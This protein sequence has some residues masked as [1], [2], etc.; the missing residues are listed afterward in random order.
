MSLPPLNLW[1]FLCNS[2]IST[3]CNRRPWW[4]VGRKDGVTLLC[5]W[6]P[7][8]KEALVIWRGS[9]IACWGISVPIFTHVGKEVVVVALL[10]QV[11]SDG[12]QN[13]SQDVVAYR[14]HLWNSVSRIPVTLMCR[15]TICNFS[16]TQ[17]KM[18]VFTSFGSQVPKYRFGNPI[19][20]HA[21]F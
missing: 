11:R 19:Y 12:D 3:V 14:L 9:W 7:C 10:V 1:G 8:I 2:K 6:Q 13:G 4:S 17:W 16:T 5:D 18:Q 15:G 21:C 20:C